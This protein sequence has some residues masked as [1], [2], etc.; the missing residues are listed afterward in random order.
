[1]ERPTVEY[2]TYSLAVGTIKYSPQVV[3]RTNYHEIHLIWSPHGKEETRRLIKVIPSEAKQTAE[4]FEL[5]LGNNLNGRKEFI[6]ENGHKYLD[7][8]D[9]S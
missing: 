6:S 4:A 7:F 9:V 3:L 5:F 2:R 8:A 1:M